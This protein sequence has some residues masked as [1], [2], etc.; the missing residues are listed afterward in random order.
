MMLLLSRRSCTRHNYLFCSYIIMC[1]I[2]YGCMGCL[3]GII[4]TVV[5]QS[6]MPLRL[7]Y[8]HEGDITKFWKWKS[9][10][11]DCINST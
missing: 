8:E 10:K 6:Q 2:L 9:A 1:K 7:W 5:V 4:C 3:V 11:E